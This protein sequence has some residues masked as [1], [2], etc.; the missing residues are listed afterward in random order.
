MVAVVQR[1]DRASVCVGGEVV[2]SI[3]KGLA[4]LLG[5]QKGDRARQARELSR[6]C[7]ELRIFEDEGGKMNLSLPE[8]GGEMLVVSQFTL[9]ADTRKGRRPSFAGAAPPDVAENLY[10]AF[11]EC[12]RG[13]GVSVR[14]GRFGAKMVIELV[15]DGP[16]TF[17]LE[18]SA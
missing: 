7:V 3:R 1:V 10:E 17:V 4:V 18:S 13:G 6:K 2:S 12:A 11:M 15:N 5:V 16:V 14:G 9:C 8:V